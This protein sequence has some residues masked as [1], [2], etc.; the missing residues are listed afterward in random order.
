MFA[1]MNNIDLGAA[2]Q[3]VIR[4]SALI[5]LIQHGTKVVVNV[6][7]YLFSGFC[8]SLDDESMKA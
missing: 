2:P 8:Y 4:L 7:S 1:H 3:V 5:R 6:L